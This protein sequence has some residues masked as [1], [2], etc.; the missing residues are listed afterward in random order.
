MLDRFHI[1]GKQPVENDLL[2]SLV[3]GVANACCSCFS[4]HPKHPLCIRDIFALSIL[5]GKIGSMILVAAS[6]YHNPRGQHSEGLL[7]VHG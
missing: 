2:K 6:T 1:V 4:E 7:Q 3:I 5:E